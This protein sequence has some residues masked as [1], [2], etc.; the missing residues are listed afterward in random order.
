MYVC[1]REPHPHTFLLCEVSHAD[2][3]NDGDD[4]DDDASKYDPDSEDNQ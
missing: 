2:D 3:D 4:D 1:V